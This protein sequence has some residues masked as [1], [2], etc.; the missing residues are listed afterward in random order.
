MDNHSGLSNEAPGY[1]KVIA[2]LREV[3][4][5]GAEATAEEM[6]AALR[7]VAGR[8]KPAAEERARAEPAEG[9]AGEADYVAAEA[10]RQARAELRATQE[11]QSAERVERAVGGALRE[12][13]I[14]P[15]QRAWALEYCAQDYDGFAAFAARQPRLSLGE[16]S[17]EGSVAPSY[18]G[19]LAG[20]AADGGEL[21]AV[22]RAVC[23]RLGISASAYA[24]RKAVRA[25]DSIETF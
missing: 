13:R 4:E 3:L 16:A 11:R 14:V 9:A 2:V 25:S 19:R 10:L 12:G 17:G 20:R 7:E 18:R 1:D 6:A 21:G 24:S 8:V 22:E 23:T 15:A 5:L